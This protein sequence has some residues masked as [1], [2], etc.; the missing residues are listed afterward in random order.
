MSLIRYVITY[1]KIS[2]IC[3]LKKSMSIESKSIFLFR[4]MKYVLHSL[5]VLIVEI[6]S[7]ISVN[8]QK[9]WIEVNR[10]IYPTLSHWIVRMIF[11][12]RE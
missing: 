1:S 8:V 11:L 12:N 6:S 5:S 7:C 2:E 3:T 4:C 9:I 10:L